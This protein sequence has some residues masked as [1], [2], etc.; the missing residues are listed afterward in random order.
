LIFFPNRYLLSAT[1]KKTKEDQKS[2]NMSELLRLCSRSF[3]DDPKENSG[4]HNDMSE[5]LSL[6]SGKFSHAPNAKAPTESQDNMN[7]LLGLCSGSFTDKKK[8]SESDN[9][10]ELL[11]LCSGTF[12]NKESTQSKSTSETQNMNELLGLC[13]GKFND[14]KKTTS[15]SESQDMNE[16]LGLC[17]GKFDATQKTDPTFK[18]QNSN[19]LFDSTTNISVESESTKKD[20]LIMNEMLR[21]SS[22]QFNSVGSTVN[23]GNEKSVELKN[24]IFSELGEN[25]RKKPKSKQGLSAM[26]DRMKDDASSMDDVLA[27]CSGKLSLRF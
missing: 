2:K 1:K 7:E 8:N 26:F 27:L 21:E 4:S 24:G 11:G 25:A 22:G 13:S 16:L 23:S 14:A 3:T 9:M 5:L 6:C 10:S 20:Q 15:E 12:G 17:S 18:S 19:D